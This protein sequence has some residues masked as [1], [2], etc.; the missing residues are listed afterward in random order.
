MQ[1]SAY[2]CSETDFT[3]EFTLSLSSHHSAS[4][5]TTH[6]SLKTCNIS[7]NSNISSCRSPLTPCFDYRTSNYKSYC[8]PG[9]LCSLLEPCDNITQSCASNTS[10]CIINSCCS[11]QTVCLPLP[12]TSLCIPANETFTSRGRF[13]SVH[14]LS[15]VQID[16]LLAAH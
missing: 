6:C 3:F 8:A 13:R 12:L 15:A 2:S 5:P 1:P 11:I 9:I 10:V 14:W 4:Q 16:R 7:S